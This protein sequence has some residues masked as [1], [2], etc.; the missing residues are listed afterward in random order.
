[1]LDQTPPATGAGATTQRICGWC[2]PA[3]VV[4]CAVGLAA[5]ARFVPPPSASLSAADLAS[6]FRGGSTAIRIGLMLVVFGAALF[7]PFVAVISAQM[8]RIEG[9]RSPLAYAQLVLG[10]CFIMEIIF[11]LMAVQTAAYR[12]ERADPIQQA[13]NDFGWLTFFG[14]A[15]TAFVEM[16]IIG[17]VILQDSRPLPVF[18]RWSGYFNIWVG[19]LYTPGTVVVFFRSGPLAWTGLFVFWLP[20][21]AFFAWLITMAYLLL[22]AVNHEVAE[23]AAE[24]READDAQA[25]LTAQLARVTAQLEALDSRMTRA[26]QHRVG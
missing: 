13:L 17:V 16:V 2:G 11:P 5:F 15:S 26:E 7:G 21:A 10:A 4:T 12:P 19:L 24:S 18:P 1:M 22:K 14:V 20:F 6:L 8:K 3:V 9:A 25:Q 23:T